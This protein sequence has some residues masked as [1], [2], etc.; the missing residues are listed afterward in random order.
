MFTSF[1][2]QSKTKGQFTARN[3][4]SNCQNLTRN[5]CLMQC[6]Y[7]NSLSKAKITTQTKEKSGS[8]EKIRVYTAHEL[9]YRYYCYVLCLMLIVKNLKY[10]SANIAQKQEK[11]SGPNWLKLMGMHNYDEAI[12]YVAW[13]MPCSKYFFVLFSG[14]SWKRIIGRIRTAVKK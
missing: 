9:K 13:K 12:L 10:C 2:S 11:P 4:S 1:L 6:I 5:D 3:V 7:F 8:A 14:R